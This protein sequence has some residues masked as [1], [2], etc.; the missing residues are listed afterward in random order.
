MAKW[1]KNKVNPE[2]IN[3]GNEYT[4]NDNL[5]VEAINGIINNSINAQENA[6]RAFEL[7]EGANKANGTVV[8]INGEPQ[9]TWDATTVSNI[10]NEQA[11]LL[12]SEWE[13]SLNEFNINEKYQ[14]TYNVNTTTNFSNGKITIFSKNDN[15]ATKYG[16]ITKNIK[17]I[18]TKENTDYVISYKIDDP[19]STFYSTALFHANDEVISWGNAYSKEPFVI[20]SSVLSNYD[21]VYLVFYLQ[22]ETASGLGITI[23]EIQ[24]EEGNIAHD[25]QPYNGGEIVRKGDITPVVLWENASPNSSFSNEPMNFSSGDYVR[26]VCFCKRTTSDSALVSTEFLK[27][28]PF[29]VNNS[30]TQ[31]G[32]GAENYERRFVRVNDTQYTG[33]S[34]YKGAGSSETA[35]NEYLIPII[36]LGFKY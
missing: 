15:F 17:D 34:C 8:E 5:S 18:F 23:S 28:Y 9:G 7:A 12:K 22:N 30:H 21:N 10:T 13:K 27:G 32:V 2:Q 25:Y 36:I 3:N 16:I 31:S 33:E 29:I 6:E 14:A 35:T 20:N 11:D 19:N 4:T 24:I 26:G 1:T